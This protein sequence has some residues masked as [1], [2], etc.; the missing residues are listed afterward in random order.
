MCSGQGCQNE[1]RRQLLLSHFHTRPTH[2][3]S[4]H[5]PTHQTNPYPPTL[6]QT[7]KVEN[8]LRAMEAGALV[9]D[10]LFDACEAE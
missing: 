3:L 4:L 7:L 10:R 8:V 2:G 5:S 1:R 6:P 9:L